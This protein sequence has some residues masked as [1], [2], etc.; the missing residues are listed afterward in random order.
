MPLSAASV[1][2]SLS[3]ADL[4]DGNVGAALRDTQQTRVAGEE[5]LRLVEPLDGLKLGRREYG[6][7]LASDAAR[8]ADKD[9]V[10]SDRR[11]MRGIAPL[12]PRADRRAFPK[13]VSPC[14]DTRPPCMALA[15]M[16]F[17]A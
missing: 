7:D 17:H 1:C 2:F 6:L 14:C 12:W 15:S 11:R 8:A 13:R 10:A 9:R 4:L 3:G 16:I 5:L